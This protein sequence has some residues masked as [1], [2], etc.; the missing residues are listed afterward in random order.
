MLSIQFLAIIMN[1]WLTKSQRKYQFN[2]GKIGFLFYF[3][4]LQPNDYYKKNTN[5]VSQKLKKNF[6]RLSPE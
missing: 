2:P 6:L 4:S 3:I 5:G 1:F